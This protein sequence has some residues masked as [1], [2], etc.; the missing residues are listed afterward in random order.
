MVITTLE[1]ELSPEQGK[2]ITAAYNKQTSALGGAQAPLESFLVQQR[3][4]NVW[5]IITVW[6]SREALEAMRTSGETPR[7]IVIFK[8]VGAEPKLSLFDVTA[9]YSSR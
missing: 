5:R 1:A 8:A 6:E 4:A 7:G 9:Q 3:D 2:Q